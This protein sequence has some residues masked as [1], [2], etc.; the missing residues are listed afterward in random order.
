MAE[1]RAVFWDVDGTLADTEMDGHRPSFNAAFEDLGLPIYWDPDLYCR[2]LSIPGG[3]PRVKQYCLDIGQR[4]SDDQLLE[5]RDLKRNHYLNRVRQGHVGW[6]PGVARL[7]RDL[8]EAGLQQWIVTSS[9]GA[10]VA[11]LLEAAPAGLPRFDGVV[12]SD[13]VKD[14]K[15]SP[16]VY[17]LAL[18]RCGLSC[19]D[20][21]AIEDS[22]AGFQAA[23]AA[24]LSCLVTPSPWDEELIPL[25]PLAAAVFEHLGDQDQPAPQLH[26]PACTEGLVTLKY[27][28]ELIHS[29]SS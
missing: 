9:G 10:S 27:L 18:H 24:E 28:Q 22:A 7:L 1:L 5:L 19:V 12:C 17:Q 14:G 8:S 20:V 26:G 29:Q 3:L 15:P 23:M 21:L 25:L 2:L 13:D 4:I 11:A 16:A 6:R